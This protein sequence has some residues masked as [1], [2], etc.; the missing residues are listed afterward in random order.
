MIQ[1]FGCFSVVIVA[2][3]A[4]TYERDLQCKCKVGGSTAV[5]AAQMPHQSCVVVGGQ[6]PD[7]SIVTKG[8]TETRC[9][10][11]MCST[12]ENTFF[13]KREC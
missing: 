8:G 4:A 10:C 12:R 13:A 11:N 6:W 3:V 5:S 2:I 7:M 1:Y 9:C